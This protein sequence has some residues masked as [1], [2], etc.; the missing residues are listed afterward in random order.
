M[1]LLIAACIALAAGCATPEPM[2][3]PAK[4]KPRAKALDFKREGFT[5]NIW[6]C[7]EQPEGTVYRIYQSTNLIDWTLYAVSTNLSHRLPCDLPAAFYTVGAYVNGIEV[8]AAP[9]CP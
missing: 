9:Y 3:A 7:A 6:N 4:D 2:G 8:M 1:K 5:I